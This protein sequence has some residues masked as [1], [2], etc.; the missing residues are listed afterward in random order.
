M[1]LI[2]LKNRLVHLIEEA[3]KGSFH[4]FSEEAIQD[5]LRYILGPVASHIRTTHHWES[6][7]YQFRNQLQEEVSQNESYYLEQARESQELLQNLFRGIDSMLEAQPEKLR[8]EQDIRWVRDEEPNPGHGYF[9]M[10]GI[11][12]WLGKVMED[13]DDLQEIQTHLNNM[14]QEAT[15]AKADSGLTTNT[16]ASHM[17]QEFKSILHPALNRLRNNLGDD[18][19]EKAYEQFLEKNLEFYANSFPKEQGKPIFVKNLKSFK[20]SEDVGTD[21]GGWTGEKPNATMIYYIDV[22]QGFMEFLQT[23]KTS[24]SE[25]N[26]YPSDGGGGFDSILALE[27]DPLLEDGP[28]N[29]QA[30]NDKG[31]ATTTQVPQGQ[32]DERIAGIKYRK[33]KDQLWEGYKT[34][35]FTKGFVQRIEAVERKFQVA[36]DDFLKN[37]IAQFEQLD[38]MYLQFRQNPS[39]EVF[40][41]MIKP[42]CVREE[43]TRHLKELLQTKLDEETINRELQDNDPF[44]RETEEFLNNV[45]PKDKDRLH[46]LRQELE[47]QHEKTGSGK[48]RELLNLSIE[49]IKEIDQ[50]LENNKTRAKQMEDFKKA[51]EKAETNKA[52]EDLRAK[53]DQF[54][55]PK[56]EGF[57]IS[58]EERQKTYVLNQL[59]KKA[60]QVK[61]DEEEKLEKFLQDFAEVSDDGQFAEML[62][63]QKSFRNA[64]KEDRDEV[65]QLVKERKEVVEEYVLKQENSQTLG[66]KENEIQEHIQLALNFITNTTEQI[67]QAETSATLNKFKDPIKEFIKGYKSLDYLIAPIQPEADK[68]ESLFKQRLEEVKELEKFRKEQAKA[69]EAAAK[70]AEKLEKEKAKTEASAEKQRLAE[71]R[72]AAEAAIQ[73][74]AFLKATATGASTDHRPQEDIFSDTTAFDNDQGKPYPQELVEMEEKLKE[75]FSLDWLEKSYSRTKSMRMGIEDEHMDRLDQ[76]TKNLLHEIEIFEEEED[77]FPEHLK[78]L[79]Q[80]LAENGFDPLTLDRAIEQVKESKGQITPV[81]QTRYKALGDRLQEK[82]KEFS[83]SPDPFQPAPI[84][85]PYNSG[86]P[87]HNHQTSETSA[88]TIDDLFEDSA[89]FTDKRDQPQTSTY[90]QKKQATKDAL[91]QKLQKPKDAIGA[92]AGTVAG[93][94]EVAKETFSNPNKSKRESK[95]K[96]LPDGP[97]NEEAQFIQKISE[98]ISIQMIDGVECYTSEATQM[99]L[100]VEDSFLIED[101]CFGSNRGMAH[102][103]SDRFITDQ[104]NLQDYHLGGGYVNF[105]EIGIK[106]NR[107]TGLVEYI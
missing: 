9:I 11:I 94:V 83:K 22:V 79:E 43:A 32:R 100:P 18:Y 65:A 64:S 73:K 72:R 51:L 53:L 29:S 7:Q 45:Q 24:P 4:N 81:H 71:K 90:E 92:V 36:P 91:H 17:K 96:G 75:S 1:K 105:E 23:G 87:V 44:L 39:Q 103:L 68:M 78:I 14:K 98:D 63:A 10:Q 50:F 84:S 97:I 30:F 69:E 19:F 13:D 66:E 3:N 88:S 35:D 59:E 28:Q 49:K 104:K 38:Q 80:T 106:I 41:Q 25:D 82:G 86:K 42:D 77:P 15:S 27:S 46:E 57:N 54:Y 26:I 60:Q 93:V 40:N 47:D 99:F 21:L 101:I 102:L 20:T 5:D 56:P 34:S 48:V 8:D 58:V 37:L 85:D 61:D 33:K 67:N 70:E 6:F 52:I 62:E 95:H 55:D 74:N 107:K 16:E 2:D 31:D 76:L 89:A 12:K